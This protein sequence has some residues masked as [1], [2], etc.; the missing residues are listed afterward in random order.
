M[1]QLPAAV[2]VADFAVEVVAC[3]PVVCVLVVSAGV[4]AIACN[5]NLAL[6]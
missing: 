5:T 4:A 3:A 1:T 6:P 2:E